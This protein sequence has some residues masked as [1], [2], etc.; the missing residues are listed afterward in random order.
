MRASARLAPFSRKREKVA[1]EVG[2]M[3]ALQDTSGMQFAL[4]PATQPNLSPAGANA[5][6]LLACAA[7][8][9]LGLVLDRWFGL[10]PALSARCGG[11]RTLWASLEWHWT[12][13]PATCLTMLFGAP[14]WM[15]LKAMMTALRPTR[16]QHN[17]RNDTFAACACH[18][19]M[20]AGMAGALGVGP[21]LAALAGSPW[22][23]GGAIGAMA[24]GMFGGMGAAGLL[25]R[26][27]SALGL[28]LRGRAG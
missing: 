15:G 7:A 9:P 6:V 20:M 4:T 17:C 22:T 25:A 12:C 18:L 10:L 27:Q 14:A 21:G 2:R 26:S 23:S 1:D 19:A 8:L 11:S 3:R 24:F 28:R 13:V 16:S 5:Q